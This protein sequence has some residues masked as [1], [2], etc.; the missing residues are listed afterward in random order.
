M[1]NNSKADIFLPGI[2]G[3]AIFYLLTFIISWSVWSILILFPQAADWAPVIIILGAYGPLLASLILSRVMGDPSGARRWFRSVSGVRGQWRW[4]LFGG[5]ILPLLIALVHLGLYRLII[6]SFALSVDP[7][8]YWAASVIPLNIL[9]LFW[10]S[11]AI[12]EFGWQGFAMPRLVEE[13]HPLL[14]CLVHGIIWATWHIPLYFTGG[15]KGDDQTIWLLYAITLTLTPIMF[16]LTRQASGSVI[17]AVL[18]HAATNHYSA[19]FA[20][21]QT[22]PIFVEPL[23]IYFTEIKVGI[24]LL[25]AL[26]LI[27]KTRGQLGLLSSSTDGAVQPVIR[28]INQS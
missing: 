16:W 8:W 1:K 4:I 23:S 13:M 21:A 25:I 27:V 6:G 20:Q 18:L 10:M 22:F 28:Y 12:E 26:I 24:Y 2:R 7:P 17:P 15:W 11:S 5:L 9:V 14:V 3:A 19:V